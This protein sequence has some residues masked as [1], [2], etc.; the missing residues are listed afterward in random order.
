MP[1]VTA[2]LVQELEAQEERGAIVS[3]KRRYLVEGLSESDPQILTS[4]LGAGG[5]PAAGSSPTGFD[6]LVLVR[7]VPRLVPNNK[8]KVWVDCEYLTL[9]E[10]KTGFV[11]EG[12]VSI[13]QIETGKDNRG[14]DITVTHTYPSDDPDYG[15]DSAYGGAAITQGGTV[16]V[17][18]SRPMM[19]FVGLRQEDE[20]WRLAQN[21][22]TRL[23]LKTGYGALPLFWMCSGVQWS[24]V[25]SSTDP[26]T[27]EFTFEFAFNNQGWTPEVF[28]VDPRTGRPPENLVSGVGKKDVQWYLWRDFNELFPSP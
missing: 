9:P 12:G 11:P 24:L 28:F 16:Q 10:A 15:D 20:P 23:N 7:R 26:W 8:T 14:R 13:L 3:L 4:A 27:Y 22:V 19:R 2:D 6:N 17:L 18:T 1:T 25:D 21:W 5:V